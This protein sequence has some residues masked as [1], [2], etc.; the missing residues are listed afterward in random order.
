MNVYGNAGAEDHEQE[1]YIHSK[2]ICEWENRRSEIASVDKTKLKMRMPFMKKALYS[3]MS[4][5]WREEKTEYI[6][7][8]LTVI[9]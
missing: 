3:G 1:T 7:T 6:T 5:G 9:I 2:D 8:F 4:N